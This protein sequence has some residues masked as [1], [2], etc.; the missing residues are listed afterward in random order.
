VDLK[1]TTV[2]ISERV[3]SAIHVTQCNNCHIQGSCQQLRIHESSHVRFKVESVA[4]AILEDSSDLVFLVETS[5]SSDTKTLMDVKDFNWL[6]I[7]VP[8]PNFRIE[9][10]LSDGSKAFEARMPEEALNQPGGLVEA[11]QQSNLSISATAA[12]LEPMEESTPIV[13]NANVKDDR[14]D[15]GNED[16]DDDEL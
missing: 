12:P 7:G 2:T 16:D 13:P 11:A 4:G 10:A 15:N 5:S 8:S 3:A 1:D 6:H 9:E 14:S